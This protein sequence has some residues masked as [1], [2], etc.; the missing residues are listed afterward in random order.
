MS[1]MKGVIYTR[2]STTEQAIDRT[3]LETQEREC[4]DYARKHRVEVIEERIFRE[5]GESAKVANRPELQN[6]LEYVRKHKGDIEVLYIWKIDRLSRNLG[7]YYGIKVALDRL[8]VRIVSVTEPIDDDPVGRFLEAILAA[9]AQFDN[10]IRA[11]RTVGG[12]R[13]RVLQGEW[14]HAAP[15]GYTKKERRVIPDKHFGPIVTDIL[16]TFSKGGYNLSTIREYA[17]QKGITTKKGGQK[18]SD[19]MKAILT[20]PIYAGYTRN[21]LV[22]GA[23]TKGLHKPLVPVEVI[24]K[25]QELISGR[26]KNYVVRGDDLYPLK[27]T[28]CCSNCGTKLRASQS[29]GQSGNLYPLYHCTQKTCKKSVTGKRASVKVETVHE[30]FRRLLEALKPLDEGIERLFKDV[31]LRVWNEEYANSIKRIEYLNERIAEQRSLRQKV[32]EKFVADKI[33]E[34]ERNMQAAVIDERTSVLEQDLEDANMYLE[35]NEEVIDKAMVF[36]SDPAAF[37]NR[38]STSVK[39]MVQHLLFPN[40]IVYDF[41][42]GFG[43]FDKL[44]SHLLIKKMTDKSVKYSALVAATGIEPVTLGL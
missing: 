41:E 17:F 39:Q 40:G 7:D 43:T 24:E 15:V 19:A 5:K 2:V 3:S 42:T 16:T 4:Q 1:S 14:P 20:N 30:D 27:G 36:I 34:A 9:A 38:A 44:E 35:Q 10:E 21:K 8:G 29:K 25:N 6:M 12:M 22:D 11:I 31:V 18:T 28:L 37:W 26:R 33:S 23:L 32:T 13:A